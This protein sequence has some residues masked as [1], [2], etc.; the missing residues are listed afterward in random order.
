LI[1][2]PTF[3]GIRRPLTWLRSAHGVV[4]ETPNV[5]GAVDIVSRD[6]CAVSTVGSRNRPTTRPGSSSSKRLPGGVQRFAPDLSSWTC[7]GGV[8]DRSA[9]REFREF[10]DGRWTWLAR[11]AYGLTGDRGLAEDLAQTALANAYAAWYRVRRAD[12]PDAYLR[13]IVLNA[14]RANFRKPRS[15]GAADRYA[16][17]SGRHGHA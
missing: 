2:S 8:V 10:V 11:F 14:H 13:R 5:V 7:E 16:G 1:I 9:E 6:H 4:I 3:S 12:D 17:V 15:Q